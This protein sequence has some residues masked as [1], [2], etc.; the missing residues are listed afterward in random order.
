M[1]KITNE[2]NGKKYELVPGF[3]CCGRCAFNSSFGCTLEECSK[4]FNYR[5]VC[6]ILLGIWK[7]VR[8]AD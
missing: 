1:I 6:R 8:N 4:D 7:E 2:I 3:G 5:Q